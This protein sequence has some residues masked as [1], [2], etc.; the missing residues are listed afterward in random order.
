M[1][2][3]GIKEESQNVESRSG[4]FGDQ[5]RNNTLS[6]YEFFLPEVEQ[7]GEHLSEVSSSEAIKHEE[8]QKS[9]LADFFLPHE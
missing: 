3:E 7:S 2:R 8:E 9:E 6:E 4:L 5:D 1:S